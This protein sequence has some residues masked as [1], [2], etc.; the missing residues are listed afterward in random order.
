MES[1]NHAEQKLT[2]KSLF[3][4]YSLRIVCEYCTSS[5][6][7][8]SGG[9]LLGAGEDWEGVLE[10]AGLEVELSRDA[11]VAF[12]ADSLRDILNESPEENGWNK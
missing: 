7:L 8:L 4:K 6:T 2:C 10:G 12:C 9:T 3:K 11:E 1:I 5:S